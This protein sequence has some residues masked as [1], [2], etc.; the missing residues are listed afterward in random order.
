MYFPNYDQPGKALTY[1]KQ[2]SSPHT[3]SSPTNCSA[4]LLYLSSPSFLLALLTTAN[5]GLPIYQPSQDL[6]MH[7]KSVSSLVETKTV[8]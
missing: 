7:I 2:L 4:Y 1:S 8:A 3:N 5:P 6:A